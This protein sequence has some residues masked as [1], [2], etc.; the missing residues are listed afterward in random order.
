MDSLSNSATN[1]SLDSKAASAEPL[2]SGP[3]ADAIYSRSIS[4]WQA[5]LLRAKSSPDIPVRSLDLRTCL[6]H[7]P[8]LPKTIPRGSKWIDGHSTWSNS[9]ASC[10]LATRK[11]TSRRLGLTKLHPTICSVSTSPSFKTWGTKAN[12]GIALL[13]LAWT[14]IS[15]AELAERQGLSMKYGLLS[16]TFSATTTLDLNYAPGKELRWWKAIVTSGVGWSVAGGPHT[17]WAVSVDDIAIKISGVTTRNYK[18]PTAHEAACYLSRLCHAY[19]LGDQAS[20]ALAAALTIPLHSST[21]SFRPAKLKLPP[22]NFTD[23]VSSPRSSHIVADY[24]LIG[25]YMTLSLSPWAMGPSLWSVFW[26]PD[27]PC[28]FAGAWLSPV[29][30][31]LEPIIIGD[32]MELLAKA[33]STNNMSPLWLGVALCGRGPIINCVL[34]SLT[35][36]HD[37]P[38]TRP[39]TDAA[40]WTGT[41]QSFFDSQQMPL[42]PDGTVLRADVWRLRHDCFKSYP[43]DTFSHTTPF[44]WPPFGRMQTTDVEL[45]IVEHLSCS[46]KWEYTHWTWSPDETDC[47]FFA[48]GP[49]SHQ[50]SEGGHHQPPEESCTVASPSWHANNE[51]KKVVHYVSDIATK[52]V[53]WW[54]CGQVEKGFGGTIVPFRFG[55]D[56][57]VKTRESPPHVDPKVIQ[58]WLDGIIV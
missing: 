3:E 18:P 36:M 2:Y 40:A 26:D 35:K 41:S 57:P 32:D 56:E 12:N 38:F 11:G 47:G 8:Q 28:N 16:E 46:H 49:P 52:S 9:D 55:P 44:G 7:V 13:V 34:S 50:L 33:L 31:L 48:N 42:G 19:D 23:C 24:E 22:P 39:R 10:S 5:I 45:E 58:E 37:Y 20:A 29:A 51:E 17:P 15:S 54:S 53:F 6:H 43:D 27:V 4:R 14:Y 1:S 25:Y 21:S 30:T